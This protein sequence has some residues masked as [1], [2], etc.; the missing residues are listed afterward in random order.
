MFGSE[1]ISCSSSLSSLLS[2]FRLGDGL[3]V[4]LELDLSERFDM[5]FKSEL[6]I[7]YTTRTHLL[8]T[9]FFYLLNNFSATPHHTLYHERLK[10]LTP[11]H[12]F[13]KIP[14]TMLAVYNY[15]LMPI[16]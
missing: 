14:L 2:L 6:R 11:E 8:Y 12:T 9:S 10:N 5:S 3:V 15:I 1:S 13:R 7:L 16:K 4:E